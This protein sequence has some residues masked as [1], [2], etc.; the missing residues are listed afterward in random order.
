MTHSGGSMST[1]TRRL[2][3]IVRMLAITGLTAALATPAAAQFGGLKKKAQQT[4]GA[5]AAKKA[6][7]TTATQKGAAPAPAAGAGGGG[8]ETIVLD[9]KLV[10][11][12]IAGRKAGEAER[13]AAKKEDTPYTRYR[14]DAE[15]YKAAKA[16]CATAQANFQTRLL[17]DEKFRERYT[18]VSDKMIKAQEAGDQKQQA[19]WAD[20][21]MAMMDPACLVQEPKQ[22][23]GYY[24]EQRKID[25][26]AEEQA[27]KT[28]KL[29]RGE[30]A[31]VAERAWMILQGQ[32]PP[33][34]ASASE[35]AAVNNRSAELKPLLGLEEKPAVRTA[36]PAPA[37]S[38]PA[39]PP[40]QPAPTGMSAEQTKLSQCMAKN[41]QKH[42]K[43][44]EALGE[45][46]KA[47]AEVND[48][49]TTLAI[50]D[51]IRQ[52]QTAGCQ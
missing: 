12:Y 48:M 16:K 17:A 27:L 1:R 44:I 6:G 43:Q 30:F 35:K 36:K 38:T 41:A 40:A 19:A 34:D 29:S 11:Q 20:S 25:S 10:D 32:T 7:D 50:A 45:R 46:T 14:R 23:D 26:R 47:A 21:S 52:L 51:T 3:C 49:A 8:M 39:P 18:A 13:E 24:E 28:S 2:V 33:G 22:P 37:A 5:E 15:A 42:E 31:T 4:A 9:D